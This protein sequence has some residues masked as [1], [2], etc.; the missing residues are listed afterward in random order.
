[1]PDEPTDYPPEWDDTPPPRPDLYPWR[2]TDAERADVF[3]H[4]I[5]YTEHPFEPPHPY[6]PRLGEWLDPWR[7]THAQRARAIELLH[8]YVSRSHEFNKAFVLFHGD[9]KSD[10]S[11]P[12][13]L[14]ALL[15]QFAVTAIGSQGEELTVARLE[16]DLKAA[17][18]EVLREQGAQ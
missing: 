1:M 10:D 16:G 5:A 13:M 4:A 11:G 8:M 12:Q 9:M 18:D 14:V 17:R 3:K 2:P 15:E 6:D 7:P